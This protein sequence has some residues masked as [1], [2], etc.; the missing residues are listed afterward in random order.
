MNWFKV[1]V[2]ILVVVCACC[3]EES[4][5]TEMASAAMNAGAVTTPVTAGMLGEQGGSAPMPVP[6]LGGGA[7]APSSA[8]QTTT[9]MMPTQVGGRAMSGGT[10]LP[11]ADITPGGSRGYHVGR[12]PRNKNN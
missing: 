10:V 4:S 7:T 9:A 6:S 12:K 1:W 8:G 3:S 11:D 2:P 5:S